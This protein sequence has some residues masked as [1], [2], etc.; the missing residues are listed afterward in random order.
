[1]ET[2]TIQIKKKL[3]KKL[4]MLKIYPKEPMNS[5]IE[6]LTNMVI[7]EVPLSKEEILGIEKS[8]EEIRKGKVYTLEEVKKDAGIK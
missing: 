2:T 8:L 7:D 5:V 4:D 1:M 3:K 6:R